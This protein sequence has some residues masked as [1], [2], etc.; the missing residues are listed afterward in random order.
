MVNFEFGRWYLFPKNKATQAQMSLAEFTGS[1]YT[2]IKN[3]LFLLEIRNFLPWGFEGGVGTLKIKP[4]KLSLAEFIGSYYTKLRFL[5]AIAALYV[6][7]SVGRLV[8]LVVGRVV[9]HKRVFNFRK[10]V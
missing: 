6:A 10:H 7:M 8:G 9:G 3:F 1:Y 5:A 2:I 4:P